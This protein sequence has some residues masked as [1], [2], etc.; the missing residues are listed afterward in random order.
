MRT[1]P[2]VLLLL[3]LV[4][5]LAQAQGGA[6]RDVAGR[7]GRADWIC[8][9][10]CVE[11]VC[12]DRCLAQRCEA[13]LARLEVCTE[14]AR[15]KLDDASCSERRCGKVCQRAFEP[16]PPSPE[17]EKKDPCAG[18]QGKP[19]PQKYVGRWVLSAASIPPEPA[20]AGTRVDPQP[21][22]DYARSFEVFANGCFV[23]HTRLD[24]PT[25]GRG[26][27]LDVRAWGAF[28]LEDGEKAVTL[29][30]GDG[31]AVGP[32]CGQRRVVPLGGDPSGFRGPR[33]ELALEGD[34]L[35]LS[36]HAPSEQ[37]Y[38]FLREGASVPK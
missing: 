14:R 29:K 33:F 3:L 21:R 30:A 13:A 16:A 28:A 24:D 2:R 8:I 22:A 9:A 11:P 17:P 34:L 18:F 6:P 20:D 25:L 10:E 36:A 15:C 27:T 5:A 37:T 35:T 32:V 1:S 19:V 23:M 38:Q 12:V 26:N 7:C 31:Q 4:P